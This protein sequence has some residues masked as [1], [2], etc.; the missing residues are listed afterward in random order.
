MKNATAYVKVVG[1]EEALRGLNPTQMAIAID[2]AVEITAQE[3]EK[4][5]ATYPPEHAGNMPGPYPKRWY[6]RL[7]G[8]RWANKDGSI[9]GINS[10]EELKHSWRERLTGK[11]T[12]T[13]DTLSPKTGRA[14]SY[15]G[16]VH[17]ADVQLGVHGRHGWPT[18]QRVADDVQMDPAVEAKILREIDRILM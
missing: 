10:S 13:V 14:V 6:E 7:F 11:F 18:A 16:Y 4:R 2:K 8:P 9:G 3:V 12:R 17:D 5:M 15:G 1:L